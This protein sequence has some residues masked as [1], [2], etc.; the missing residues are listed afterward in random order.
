MKYTDAVKHLK[1]NQSINDFIQVELT[2]DAKNSKQEIVIKNA[3]SNHSASKRRMNEIIKDGTSSPVKKFT[4]K[5]RRNIDRPQT[6]Y[7]FKVDNNYS[8]PFIPKL[9]SK[10][11][12][13]V[14]L[15][16][17]II[18]VALNA[19]ETK[20]NLFTSPTHFYPHPYQAELE[21]FK[22][23]SEFLEC[24]PEEIKLPA[25]IDSTPLVV[26]S[27]IKQLESLVQ[28]LSTCKEIAIDVEH[29][30]FR[31]Y[32]GITCLIQIST[33]HKD[34]IVDVFPLWNEMQ[35]LNQVLTD[36]SIVK[37]LH[38]CDYDVIW[39]QRDLGLYIVNLFDT[40][41][42]AK[43]LDYPHASL[44][45]LANKFC[46]VKMEKHF[47]LADWR[48]RPIPEDML[49]YARNDTHYLLYIYRKMKQ[50][51]LSNGDTSANLLR[52]VMEKSR[53]LCLSVRIVRFVFIS[54]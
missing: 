24:S 18:P 5:S 44:S 51:L 34:Y 36:P 6:A 3:P 4:F 30:S 39:L 28:E 27:D 12:A 11:N 38:G 21:S 40:G 50:Q 31:T 35:M 25:S 2:V 32:Q 52:S 23:S 53:S 41:V 26:V 9:T 29:H 8:T 48:V 33:D 37:V 47:Q 22:V 42:A 10:P 1:N 49:D 19:A 14:P 43:T 17:S 20:D 45:Y 46:D 15:E 7:N 13:L 16:E 54:I